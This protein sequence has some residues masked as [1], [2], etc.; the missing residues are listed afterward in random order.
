MLDSIPNRAVALSSVM[1]AGL[2][3]KT[4]GSLLARVDGNRAI[5]SPTKKVKL[6]GSSR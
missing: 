2:E 3:A 5:D 6:L 1:I 4:D